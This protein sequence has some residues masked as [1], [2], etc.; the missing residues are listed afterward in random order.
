[1]RA[2]MGLPT[3]PPPLEDSPKCPRCS[4][5]GICLPDEV[6]LLRLAE[7]E[8]AEKPEPRRLVA[9]RDDA[10]PLYV[11]A[12]GTRVGKSGGVLQVKREGLGGARLGQICQLT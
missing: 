3:I 9:A 7:H 2:A 5:S 11:Q 6:N 12:S 8:E 10:L 4:L 1:M